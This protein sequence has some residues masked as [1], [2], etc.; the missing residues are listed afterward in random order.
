MNL[1]RAMLVVALG[2]VACSSTNSANG[3]PCTDSLARVSTTFLSCPGTYGAAVD[4]AFACSGTLQPAVTAGSDVG[5][6]LVSFSWGGTHEQIC[7]YA[8]AAT[9]SLVGALAH[10]DLPD[11]CGQSS[12]SVQAGDVPDGWSTAPLVSL[13]SS[14]DA[15][16]DAASTD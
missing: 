15:S 11:F 8:D 14:P 2:L 1:L 16:A 10:D 6:G 4:P 12:Y 3:T 7:V 5:L 13:C 9:G